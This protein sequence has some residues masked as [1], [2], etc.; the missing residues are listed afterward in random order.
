MTS[1]LNVT[2]ARFSKAWDPNATHLI[3]GTDKKGVARR[4]LNYLFAILA[5]KWILNIGC[6]AP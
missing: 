3:V 2:G 5:G 6:E 1:F 4:T